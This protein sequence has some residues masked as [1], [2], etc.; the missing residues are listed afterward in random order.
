[1][2]IQ[3]TRLF[4]LRRIEASQGS[5]I[6]RV[7]KRDRLRRG[8][9][10]CVH[11]RRCGSPDHNTRAAAGRLRNRRSITADRPIPGWRL[12]MFE[13]ESPSEDRHPCSEQWW[14]RPLCSAAG[15]VD[16]PA[17]IRRSAQ[18]PSRT[19]CYVIRNTFRNNAPL[20]SEEPENRHRVRYCSL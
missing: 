7:A 13:W 11:G 20:R 17:P 12:R 5:Q 10:R 14:R 18:P 2:H 1:V 16:S 15:F 8:H 9:R 3:Y 4:D 6:L 19:T